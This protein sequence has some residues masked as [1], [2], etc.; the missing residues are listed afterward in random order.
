MSVL[1]D[2]FSSAS[3][4]GAAAGDLWLNVNPISP[5]FLSGEA[6][7]TAMEVERQRAAAEGREPD[8][9]R[10]REEYGRD[11]IK[12][13]GEAASRTEEE[14]EERVSDTVDKAV[15]WGPWIALGVGIV[16]IAAAAIIY[17]PKPR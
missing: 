17:L 14:I 9:A 4:V 16:V 6:N 13:I 10:A 3:A 8:Y 12:R 7:L 15:T 1:S 11:G 5:Y 2:F